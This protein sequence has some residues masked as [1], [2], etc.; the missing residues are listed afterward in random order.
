MKLPILFLLAAFACQAQGD[1]GETGATLAT[2]A[3][4]VLISSYA[5]GT[6]NGFNLFNNQLWTAPTLTV[7]LKTPFVGGANNCAVL[8]VT[9]HS[10]YTV[11]T[12]SGWVAGPVSSASSTGVKLWLFY[13][14]GT[15]ANTASI[16]VTTSG[17][18]SGGSL[19]N[20]L[21]A[22]VDEFYNCGAVGG[23]GSMNTA[24]NGS[25]LT[26]TLSSAPVSGDLVLGYFI[27]V[28]ANVPA[29]ASIT[30]GSGFTPISRQRTYGKISEYNT[31]TSSTAVTVTYPNNSHTILGVGIVIKEGTPGHGPPAGKYIDHWSVENLS[32]STTP[33]FDFP[34]TGD[35]LVGMYD[36]G[37]AA[38]TISSVAGSS[39]TW[40][41]PAG[42]LSNTHLVAQ[43]AYATSVTCSST[44]TITPTFASN[45][46]P[47]VVWFGSIT[48]ANSSAPLDVTAN[49]GGN[50]LTAAN[51]TG[52]SITP[53]ALNEMT[54]N[55]T[56]IAFHTITGT[57]ADANSHTPT[58]LFSNSSPADDTFNS[59]S[60]SSPSST[61][62]EDDGKAVYINTGDTLQITFIYSGTQTTGSCTTN[63]T[64]VQGWDSVAAS[65][66]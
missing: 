3:T 52:V 4:P 22:W 20:A 34:C 53:G 40:S 15:T 11:N 65:F 39:G 18:A 66:K 12:P 61:L 30:P 57:V 17:T 50:Q 63:P 48:N 59:C 1:F 14:L 56:A 27:D 51:L 36:G 10:N 35:L 5:T 26:L 55:T 2:I 60:V 16:S 62:D 38:A 21:G 44:L 8:A 37:T 42:S 47:G 29:L 13:L 6:D 32:T 19:A 64:G 54:L 45:P 23:S 7:R 49:T 25:A 43:I 33:T 46:N 28:S 24:A 41:T 31:A 58:A 9:A